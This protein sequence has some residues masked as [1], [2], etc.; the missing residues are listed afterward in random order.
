MTPLF[1]E[2]QL[3]PRVACALWLGAAGV[4]LW[5]ALRFPERENTIS[6][7]RR[8]L[9]HRSRGQS[10]FGDLARLISVMLRFQCG[11]A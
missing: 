4:G 8:H 7:H 3:D 1:A 11:R 5:S 10:L 6:D 2:S 9:L